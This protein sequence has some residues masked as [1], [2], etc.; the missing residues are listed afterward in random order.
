MARSIV[1]RASLLRRSLRSMASFWAEAAPPVPG[2]EPQSLSMLLSP[3][4]ASQITIPTQRLCQWNLIG[5]SAEPKQVD[6]Y[7]DEPNASE[8]GLDVNL[9]H[10]I[11]VIIQASNKVSHSNSKCLGEK[12]VMEA[13]GTYRYRIQ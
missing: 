12:Y 3:S 6:T 2:F 4:A 11:L 5:S 9:A 10:L 1:S 13:K 8:L 7:T